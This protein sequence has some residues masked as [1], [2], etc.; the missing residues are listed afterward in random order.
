MAVDVPGTLVGAGRNADVFDVGSGRVLRRYRDGREARRVE[1]EAQ[2]M[3]R[4]RA[5]GVPVPEV[6]EV[7]GSDIVMERAVGP[8]MLDAV[9]RRPWTVRA[10]ARLLAR[11]H[12]MVHQV[13]A[14]ALD[15]LDL[16]PRLWTS[17][18]GTDVLLHRDLHPINVILTQSG[19]MII[20]WEGAT[21]GPAVADI[22]LT[23]AIL[24]FS[25]VPG[26]RI[27]AAL[28]QGVRALFTRSFVRAAGPLDD[29]WRLTAIRHR[30]ADPNVL[31][32]ER[33]RMQR[34]LPADPADPAGPAD[35]A[36]ASA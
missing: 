25:D 8:T 34:L 18:G 29:A 7:S 32:T 31:P 21:C 2:V 12:D 27:E 30:L 1:A 35:P 16:P 19:P 9:G 10:H 13:P 14:S 22:A 23:W 17:S 26:P 5:S 6:F 20:D 4:A 33:A 3:I 11:V 15:G 28:I 36:Q 24:G